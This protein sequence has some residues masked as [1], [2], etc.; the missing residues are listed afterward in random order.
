MFAFI[1]LLS[2][3]KSF[4]SVTPTGSGESF[5]TMLTCVVRLLSTVTPFMNVMVTG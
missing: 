2:R 3:M 4:M 1:S 5:S